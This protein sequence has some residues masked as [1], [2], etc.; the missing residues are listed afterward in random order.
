[1]P[2][3]EEK[4]VTGSK[5]II[6]EIRV[7]FGGRASEELVLD[8]I[9]TGAYSDIKRATQLAKVYVTKVG[10][11]SEF[12]PVNLEASDDMNYN[13]IPNISDETSREID[14]E[15]RKMLKVEYDNTL[16]VLRNNRDKLDAI[17]N[18]LLEKETVTGAEVRELINPMVE[19]THVEENRVEESEEM[20]E[21]NDLQN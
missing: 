6:A 19:G 1:M 7:L 21:I 14:L 5:D 16:N 4:L 8:D 2:L 20:K 17:A 13:W 11:N 10:M 15:V 3:P 12:G 18:L 9:S